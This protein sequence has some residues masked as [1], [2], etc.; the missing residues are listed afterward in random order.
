MTPRRRILFGKLSEQQAIINAFKSRVAADAGTF[1]A[2]ACLNQT[3]ARL[4]A[5]GLYDQASLILTPNA[6]KAAK[7]YSIKPTNGTGDF[8]VARASTAMRRNASGVW[9]SVANNV[10]R[11]HYPVGGGCPSWLNEPTATQGI[12]NSG[13]SG[14]VAGTPGTL[15]TNW[16][17]SL[18]GLGRQIVGVGTEQGLPYFD[19]RLFGT[20]S[21]GNAQIQFEANNI[22]ASSPSQIWTNS[23]FL[24]IMAQPNPPISYVLRVREALNDGTF[25]ADGQTTITPTTS[26][27]RHIQ[28]R[29]NT[30]GTTQRIQPMLLINLS[31]GVAYDFTIR[32]SVPQMELGSI[33]TSPIVTTGSALTRLADAP[34]L[35]GASSFIGQ[36][37][38]TVFIEPQ[39]QGQ[40]FSDGVIRMIASI[41]DGTTNNR[42]EIY[43]SNNTIQY[44]NI[45]G[46]AIQFSGTVFTITDF[47]GQPIK[48]AISY[49]LNNVKVFVNGVLVNT[50]TTALIPACSQ[51]NLGTNRG[52]TAQWNG[53]IGTAIL[54]PLLTDAQCIALTT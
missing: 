36:T 4:R 14:A 1:E 31:I 25:V 29:T 37:E 19:L 21:G 7:K 12:R 43:R 41:S 33:A 38:G 6:Y 22:I 16:F 53:L 15:P 40:S 39:L 44:D 24:R 20:A 30:G 32:I 48:L 50:D 18:G 46:G 17:E 27:A 13:A 51:F 35:T 26:F 45:V 9:E 52:G 10:P 2:E 34:Q 47:T 54:A 3:V 23:V 5:L 11:L 8:T 49:I 42:I 28:T